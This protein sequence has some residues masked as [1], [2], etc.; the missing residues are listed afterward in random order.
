MKKLIK[1]FIVMILLLSVNLMFSSSTEAATKVMWGKTELKLGQIGKVTILSNTTLV[2]LSNGS[3]ST[4][5]QLKKG[6]EF[7]VYSYKSNHGGLYGVGGG[8]FVQKNSKIKYET[9]SK[10]KLSLLK[11]Q[12]KATIEMVGERKH[13]KL[14]GLT[15]GMTRNEVI[16]VLGTPQREYIDT[17]YDGE[18]V[19]VYQDY[20]M[21]YY[22]ENVE[23]IKHVITKEKFFSEILNVYKGMKY[24]DNDG[25]YILHSEFANEL[26][27][28]KTENNQSFVLLTS[29]DAN[30][31][32][33]VDQG[34]YVPVK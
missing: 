21:F 33:S 13:F 7:R 6:E 14:R 31:K 10:S 32:F 16:S 12:T 18:L 22:G 4:V 19:Q 24:T 3:L 2:K 27:I 25:T 5:R 15:L 23:T 28:F 8:S 20:L 9:P 26:I 29:A 1:V 34:W 17:D 11:E 30:F